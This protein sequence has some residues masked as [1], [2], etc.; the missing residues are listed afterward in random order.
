MVDQ[1]MKKLFTA[2]LASF[3]LM[4]VASQVQA[5][6]KAKSSNPFLKYNIQIEKLKAA[7]ASANGEEKKDLQKKLSLLEDKKAKMLAKAKAPY[8]KK[9]KALQKTA[10]ATKDAT[11][12]AAL[13]KKIKIYQTQIS[14]IDKKASATPKKASATTKKEDADDSEE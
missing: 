14:K 1:T 10:A 6:A 3:I 12:K 4:S 8:E 13:D 11:K 5:E 9:L 2:I 7:V